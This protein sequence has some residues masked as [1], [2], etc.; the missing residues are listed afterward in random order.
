ME[1]KNE[2]INVR[3]IKEKIYTKISNLLP[4][5]VVVI[6]PERNPLK[7]KYYLKKKYNNFKQ[8][9]KALTF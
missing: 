7:E 3:D 6:L 8:Y 4:Q 9:M 2:N 1:A 5:D